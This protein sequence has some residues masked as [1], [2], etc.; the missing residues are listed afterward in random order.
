M[1]KSIS[2]YQKWYILQFYIKI[3][4]ND[5]FKNMV[6]KLIKI[7]N[8]VPCFYCKEFNIDNNIDYRYYSLVQ[9]IFREEFFWKVKINL[10]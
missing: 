6:P 1:F 2:R 7:L 3:E 10:S 5:V 9:N 8:K 4:N